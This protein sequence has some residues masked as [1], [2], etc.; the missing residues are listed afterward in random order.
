MD[1]HNSRLSHV[2]L[3]S[4]ISGDELLVSPGCGDALSARLIEKTGFRVAFVSGFWCAATRGLLDVGVITLNELTDSVRAIARITS[5]PLICDADTGFGESP[6]QIERCVREL[7]SA[8]AQGIQ[9]EDQTPDKKCGLLSGK[10]VISAQAMVDKI[11]AAVEARSADGVI[12]A[13]SDALDSD[14]IGATIERGH[15]YLGAGADLVFIEGFDSEDEVR[16]AAAE[17]PRRTMVFNCTPVGHGP[18]FTIEELDKLG[19]SIALFPVHLLLSS[20]AVQQAWLDGLQK[21]CDSVSPRE[22]GLYPIEGVSILLEAEAAE[23]REALVRSHRGA[24]SEDRGG[25][26]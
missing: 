17:F 3:R 19:V 5:L 16:A 15:A 10:S 9:I 14:G 11:C 21:S 25:Q 24:L 20:L 8:G 18:S 22:E 2:S 13:R 6:L 7:E 12:I 4:L 26:K 23:Q 1:E